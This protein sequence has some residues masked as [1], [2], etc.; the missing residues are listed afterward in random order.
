MNEI[1]QTLFILLGVAA[2]A[3]GMF[4]I[5]RDCGEEKYQLEAI[6]RGFA[7]WKLN[8]EDGSTEF[9]WNE[10]SAKETKP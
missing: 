10:P 2:F 9:T 3:F 8:P 4:D 7:Y 5:G 6:K 1:A